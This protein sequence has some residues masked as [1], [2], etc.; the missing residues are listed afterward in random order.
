MPGAWPHPQ[1]RVRK[2]KAHKHSH[3]RSAETFRHSPRDGVT[4]SF[5]L[6]PAIG[7]SC[8]RR[9]RIIARKLGIGV[10]MPEPH[11]FAVRFAVRPSS[12]T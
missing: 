11:D 12:R 2:V 4:V 5:V 3:H 7:L 10:E 1:P 6:F 8:H 9:L